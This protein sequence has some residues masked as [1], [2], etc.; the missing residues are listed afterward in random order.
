[1]SVNVALDDNIVAAYIYADD[2]GTANRRTSGVER[3]LAG[4]L[5]YDRA[6]AGVLYSRPVVE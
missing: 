6:S 2:I 1:M 3:A 5:S 4:A